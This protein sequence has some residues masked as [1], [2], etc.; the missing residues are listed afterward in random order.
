MVQVHPYIRRSASR[1]PNR[2]RDRTTTSDNSVVPSNARLA[3]TGLRSKCRP[4]RSRSREHSV[5]EPPDAFASID[6]DG[7]DGADPT[8]SGSVFR[9]VRE[10]VR[11]TQL[12]RAWSRLLTDLSQPS[13]IQHHRPD[14]P[15]HRTAGPGTNRHSAHEPVM[16]RHGEHPA[17]TGEGWGRAFGIRERQQPRA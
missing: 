14:S 17:R 2:A 16:T 5:L 10:R 1:C 4:S 3:G 9:M 12:L 15:A 7:A 13:G 8:A 6:R 11:P